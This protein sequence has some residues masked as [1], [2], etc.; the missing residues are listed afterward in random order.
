VLP[1]T[2]VLPVDPAYADNAM[3]QVPKPFDWSDDFSPDRPDLRSAVMVTVNG[4]GRVQLELD[5]VK[6]AISAAGSLERQPIYWP[7][8]YA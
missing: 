8:A 5:V 4:N 2:L 6:D 1:F 3:D 7:H